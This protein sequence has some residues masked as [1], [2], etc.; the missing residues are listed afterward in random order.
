MSDLRDQLLQAGLISEA[1]IEKQAK[2]QPAKH[3]RPAQS[4]LEPIAPDEIEQT[5][6]NATVEN[7][8]GRNRWYFVARDETIQWLQLSDAQH[9]AMQQGKL[10]IVEDE[11]GQA[12]LV[13][14]KVANRLFTQQSSWLRAYSARRHPAKRHA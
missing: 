8:T 9:K 7:I 4:P 3:T 1:D 14:G 6:R 11:G 10:G 13:D 12:W 5:C 2:K